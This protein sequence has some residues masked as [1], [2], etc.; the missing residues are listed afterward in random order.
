MDHAATGGWVSSANCVGSDC[1][2]PNTH[3]NYVPSSTVTNTGITQELC[4]ATGDDCITDGLV[5]I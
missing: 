5:K 3:V 4:Y 1:Q 2:S